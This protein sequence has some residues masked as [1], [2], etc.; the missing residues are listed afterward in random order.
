MSNGSKTSQQTKETARIARELRRL[1]KKRVTWEKAA[2]QV[3]IVKEDGSPDP[4]L[5]YRIALEGYEP[6]KQETRDRLGLRKICL[7]CQRGFRK[8]SSA[9]KVLAPWVVWW[10]RLPKDERER[11]IRR[12]Y[13][14]ERR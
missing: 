9:S 4:G 13:D 11:R 12:E 10:R 3:G 6:K 8:V 5:A 14:K 7:A 1:R 2:E